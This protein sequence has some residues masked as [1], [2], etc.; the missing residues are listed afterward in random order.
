VVLAGTD[1]LS[2]PF[3]GPAAAMLFV[4]GRKDETVAWKAAHTVFEA[5]P[6]SRAMLTVTEGGHQLTTHEFSAVS[7]TSIEFLR[8]SLYGGTPA[9]TA[10]A[11]I[12]TLDDQLGI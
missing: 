1:F 4:Q 9:L 12:T 10:T 7:T 5:V 2:T 3:T 8:W 11:A 6:W